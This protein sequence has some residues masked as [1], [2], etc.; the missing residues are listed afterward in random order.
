MAPSSAKFPGVW[1][2]V[3]SHTRYL[4]NQK[5]RI[6]S[7]VDSQNSF[8]AMIRISFSGEIEQLSEDA[9]RTTSLEMR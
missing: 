1:D 8:G 7:Y 3:K 9:W 2:G 6:D 5:Y 4:G